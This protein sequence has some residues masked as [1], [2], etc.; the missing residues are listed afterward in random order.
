M[1]KGM[2][3]IAGIVSVMLVSGLFLAG[4]DSGTTSNALGSSTDFEGTWNK[5]ALQ[6]TFSESAF[7]SKISGVNNAKG[8]ISVDE[9]NETLKETATHFWIGS[10][11]WDGPD[12]FLTFNY[13]F[14]DV[15]TLVLSGGSDPL[16]NGTW[17][18]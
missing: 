10:A 11:W 8:Y 3:F 13:H 12:Q 9:S 1:K 4:C 17:T 16:S 7:I 14:Q 2:F 18:K 15:N 5:G 6:I